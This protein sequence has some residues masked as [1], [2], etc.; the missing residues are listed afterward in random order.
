MSETALIVVAVVAIVA[1][2]VLRRLGKTAP[3]VF[4]DEREE[5]LTRRVAGMVRATLAQALPAVRRELGLAPSQS[6]ETLVKRA[7]YHYRQDLPERTCSIYPDRA[8]G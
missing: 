3:V 8:Q 5:R 4:A 7:V 1:A 6:D 2:V